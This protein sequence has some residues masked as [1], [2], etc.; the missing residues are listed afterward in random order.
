MLSAA[1][2]QSARMRTASS[3]VTLLQAGTGVVVVVDEAGGGASMVV[4]VVRAADVVVVL[5]EIAVL[6]VVA[7]TVVEV[8]ADVVVLA[9]CRETTVILQVAALCQ[10]SGSVAS[11]MIT[12]SPGDRPAQ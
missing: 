2:P 8:S 9:G 11:T 7:T 5:G 6:V 4:V 12:C 3:R 1:V 10:F